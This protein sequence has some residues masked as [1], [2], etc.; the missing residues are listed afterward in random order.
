MC[1]LLLFLFLAVSC[2]ESDDVETDDHAKW[3]ERNEAFF[4]TLEDSLSRGDAVWKKIKTYT[5]DPATVGL[6]T[7]YIYVKVLETGAGTAS[8]LYSDSVRISYRGRLIPT[9]AYPQGE[10]FDQTYVGNYHIKTTGVSDQLVSGTVDG[11]STALQSMHKGDRWRVFVPYNLGYGEED[12][13]GIPAYSTLIFDLTL[14]DYTTG[15]ESLL[16]WNS[17]KK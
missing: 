11:F 6:N 1:G 3:K 14:I 2:S 10:V 5:K 17:R 4:R 15:S 8:P 9:T 12:K 16:P 7:D 13:T